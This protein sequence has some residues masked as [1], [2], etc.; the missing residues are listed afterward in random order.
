MK[1]ISYK[2]TSIEVV[3]QQ[4]EKE[5]EG[6]NCLNGVFS[7]YAT[8]KFKFEEAIIKGR[9]P[10]NPKLHDGKYLSM[11]RQKNGRYQFHMKTI[12]ATA[13]LDGNAIAMAVANEIVEAFKIIKA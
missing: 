2:N 11:V 12:D 5:L 3:L 10:R 7:K 1:K 9:G 4:D 8:G 6:N 13:H